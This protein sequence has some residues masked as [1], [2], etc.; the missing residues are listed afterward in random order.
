MLGLSLVM[1]G[2]AGWEADPLALDPLRPVA[3]PAP[4]EPGTQRS[5]VSGRRV[6][7]PEPEGRLVA[8]IDAPKAIPPKPIPELKPV[9]ES[10]RRTLQPRT[11]RQV[12]YA[13]EGPPPSQVEPAPIEL[14]FSQALELAAGENPRVAFA[15]ARYQEA[16]AQFRSAQVLWLPSIRAGLSYHHHDGTLQASEGNIL[17]LS[18]SSLQTGLGVGAVGAGTTRIPG[19]VA[20]F[21][22]TDAIFQP[23]IASH[24]AAASQAFWRGHVND[25]LLDTALAYQNLLE[26]VQQLRIAEETRDNARNLAELT[27]QFARSGQ[28]PQADA[29]RARTE[30][31][32][33]RN[34]VSR[35]QEAVRVTS[36]R[37]A[38]QLHLNPVTEI[39]PTEPTV[40]PINLVQEDLPPGELVTLALSNRPELAEARSLVGEAVERYRREHYAPLL[41]SVLLGVSQGGFGGGLGGVIGDFQDRFDFD[42]IVYWEVRN[43]GLGEKSRRAEMRARRKQARARQV[44]VMD[45]V[46]R[47]VIEANTQVRARQSQI[48]VAQ[49][50]ITSASDSYKRNLARIREGQGLPIEVLQSL[51]AL[52]EARREYLR[53]VT[54]YNEAQFRLHRALGWPIQ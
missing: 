26:A 43:L 48:A 35:A 36:A 15:A 22:T 23:K 13:P 46:A 54:D 50:G 45:R 42:A 24:A 32:L 52:D 21:H 27:A 47:E 7:S 53:V 20:E 25:V 29:D 39:V 18:R 8:F 14:G 12:L 51:Q 33:R 16:L 34:E 10:S 49:E 38:E 40:V 30:L 19:V 44:E 6:Q 37:L 2:C 28:G 41:P 3:F 1:F 17:D 11:I 9:P 4:S 31:V 5:G